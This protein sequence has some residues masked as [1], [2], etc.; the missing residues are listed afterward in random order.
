ML[1]F[2]LAEFVSD[3]LWDGVSEKSFAWFLQSWAWTFTDSVE[4]RVYCHAERA[5]RV[6]SFVL[7][8]CGVQGVPG[9]VYVPASD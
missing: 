4:V 2:H 7:R 6:F 5:V 8:V 1:T 9:A 3:E